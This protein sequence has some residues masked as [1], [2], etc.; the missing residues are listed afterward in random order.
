VL[1]GG[2]IRDHVV[3]FAIDTDLDGI[4]EAKVCGEQ[5]KVRANA[6]AWSAGADGKLGSSYRKRDKQNI[7]NV[8]SWSRDKEV[9]DK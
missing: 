6:I 5:V 9:K 7:D 3:Y 8:Y 1:S 4:T 2:T